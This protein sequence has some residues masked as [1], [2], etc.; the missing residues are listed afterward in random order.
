MLQMASAWIDFHTCNVDGGIFSLKQVS[1][2][3]G[4]IDYLRV[5]DSGIT[6][7]YEVRSKDQ[8]S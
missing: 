4:T 6:R 7:N 5:L 3:Q 8:K 2:S 1:F